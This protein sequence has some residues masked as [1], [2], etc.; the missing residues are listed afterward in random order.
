MTNI[1]LDDW[2]KDLEWILDNPK[3]KAPTRYPLTDIYRNRETDEIIIK[4]AICGF[5]KDDIEIE[6]RGNTLVISGE[7]QD[8]DKEKLDIIRQHISTK[9]F[10]RIIQL[11]DKYANGK[12]SAN[13]KNGIL[14][15][16]IKPTEPLRNLIQID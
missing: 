1:Y 6:Q 16:R 15:I 11:H 4:I 7:M 5:D 9:N 3:T 14:T 2:F 12:I 10:E 8:D 13:V